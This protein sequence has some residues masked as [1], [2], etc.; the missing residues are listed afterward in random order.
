MDCR[1][2]EVSF[3]PGA[4]PKLKNLELKLYP[5]RATEDDVGIKHLLEL[6]RVV[7]LCSTGYSIDAPGPSATINNVK[8][9]AKGHSNQIT[10]IV[11]DGNDCRKEL[12]P[13]RFG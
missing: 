6:Q 2:P 7:F 13:V 8:K 11:S 5:S 9:E 1:L 10:L 12:Q 3:Q 4:M